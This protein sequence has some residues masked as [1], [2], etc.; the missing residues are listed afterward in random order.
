MIIAAFSL[1]LFWSLCMIL[2]RDRL[3]AGKAP[4]IT[5]LLNAVTDKELKQQITETLEIGDPA[6]CLSWLM[7]DLKSME[8][9]L[10]NRGMDFGGFPMGV[11]SSDKM[12]LRY[13]YFKGKAKF[14]GTPSKR[15][16]AQLEQLDGFI[17]G[18]EAELAWA[19]IVCETYDPIA[20]AGAHK[21][22]REYAHV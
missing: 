19:G 9:E 7:Y 21:E 1:I 18:Y 5:H 8:S 4:A 11:S 6:L 16:N 3:V 17:H 14:D 12:N 15:L 22:V 10:G 2:I 13:Q 20:G